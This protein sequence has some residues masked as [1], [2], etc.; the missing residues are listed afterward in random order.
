MPFGLIFIWSEILTP[1]RLHLSQRLPQ[2]HVATEQVPAH[3]ASPDENPNLHY[4]GTDSI[5]V[6][7]VVTFGSRGAPKWC[8]GSCTALSS[9]VSGQKMKRSLSAPVNKT[10]SSYWLSRCFDEQSLWF[11]ISSSKPDLHV[12]HSS[13]RLSIDKEQILGPEDL[14]S[15]IFVPPSS[16]AWGYTHCL[17]F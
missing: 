15:F 7:P 3:W 8:R 13:E 17:T 1:M 10:G 6:T 9:Q 16:I 4:Y 2:S 5:K 12:W 14:G 11:A